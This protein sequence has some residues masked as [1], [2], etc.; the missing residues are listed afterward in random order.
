MALLLALNSALAVSQ[1]APQPSSEAANAL[2]SALE[3][4]WQFELVRSGAST[5]S[6]TGSRTYV[7]GLARHPSLFWTETFDDREVA[8]TGVVGFDGSSERLYEIGSATG[9]PVE[10]LVGTVGDDRQRVRWVSAG[11]T[12]EYRGDL[13]LVS[14]DEHHFESPRFT[15]VFRRTR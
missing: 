15:V 5:P 1:P 8:V 2:L 10:Q 9:G 13:V 7:R 3:G 12:S 14:A 4:E 11:S 6:V